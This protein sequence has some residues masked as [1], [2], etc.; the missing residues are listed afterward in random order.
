MIIRPGAITGWFDL[1]TGPMLAIGNDDNNLELSKTDTQFVLKSIKTNNVQNMLSDSGFEAGVAGWHV[2]SGKATI[3]Q[4]S[5]HVFRGTYSVKMT[6]LDTSAYGYLYPA[7]LKPNT[8]YTFSAMMY[9]PAGNTVA[10]GAYYALRIGGTGIDT[11][12]NSA[13]APIGGGWTALSVTFTTNANSP[14]SISLLFYTSPTA[15]QS[16]WVDEVSLVE[17]DNQPLYDQQILTAETD[18]AGWHMVTLDFSAGSALY[19]DTDLLASS[20]DVAISFDPDDDTNVMI[21][22]GGMDRT[23]YGHAIDQIHYVDKPVTADDVSRFYSVGVDGYDVELLFDGSVVASA[24]GTWFQ[25]FPLDQY[26][27]IESS[28]LVWTG[29]NATVLTSLDGESW[30]ESVSGEAVPGLDSVLDVTNTSLFVKVVLSTV[31]ESSFIDS[32]GIVLYKYHTIGG[33][34]SD[35]PITTVKAVPL[36]DD[37]Y[38]IVERN[39]DAGGEISGAV[40]SKD[41]DTPQQPI[42]AV[43]LWIKPESGNDYV[44]DER[45]SGSGTGYLANVG[46]FAGVDSVY[47]N[48]VAQSSP[49]AINYGEWNLVCIN[50]LADS[51]VPLKFNSAGS[52]YAETVVGTNIITNPSLEVDATGYG[53]IGLTDDALAGSSAGSLSLAGLDSG[54]IT[55]TGFS[56][57]SGYLQFGYMA[58]EY[59]KVSVILGGE[60]I[61]QTTVEDGWTQVVLPITSSVTTFQVTAVIDPDK[62][63]ETVFDDFDELIIDAVAITSTSTDYFDGNTTRTNYLFN[64]T[65]D[66]NASTSTKTLYTGAAS[67]TDYRIKDIS[68]YR[69]VVSA[70]DAMNHYKL[71]VGVAELRADDPSIVQISEDSYQATSHAWSIVAT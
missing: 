36:A 31:D 66:A 64:W 24:D 39:D 54:T 18:S 55:A 58:P 71:N 15:G 52:G 43:E 10:G 34:E 50:L 35:R 12:I 68:Y 32:L 56:A 16:I 13:Q 3:E 60:T 38:G 41:F 27:T 8:T 14:T 17:G 1:G 5:E 63:F 22:G 40:L 48:G 65:G 26:G 7:G 42:R 2:I 6:A 28:K 4:S 20:D 37:D 30:S 51:F 49:A 29:N 21:I 61:D 47:V 25:V 70:E 23:Q 11:P 62:T 9:V 67:R 19:L 57:S 53:D 45:W 69:D 44:F 33:S 46:T 59:A